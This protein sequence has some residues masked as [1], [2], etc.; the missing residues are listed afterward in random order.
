MRANSQLKGIE[1]KKSS[2]IT[3]TD[4]CR[5]SYWLKTPPRRAHPSKTSQHNKT[6][7]IHSGEFILYLSALLSK[8]KI[9]K[10]MS[11]A[12]FFDFVR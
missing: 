8:R 6:P 2:L 4:M 7:Q 5:K 1:D 3:F 10:R 12:N 11:K 9:K